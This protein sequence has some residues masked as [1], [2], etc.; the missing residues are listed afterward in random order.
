VTC[1]VFKEPCN[2]YT[3]VC[4]VDGVLCDFIPAIREVARGM[5]LDLP[6]PTVLAPDLRKLCGSPMEWQTLVERLLSGPHP[7]LSAGGDALRKALQANGNYL[8]ATAPIN[9]PELNGR[10]YDFRLRW[11][12]D[13]GFPAER[14][15]YM[16]PHAKAALNGGILIEDSEPTVKL[17]NETQRKRGNGPSGLLIARPWNTGKLTVSG[18][19]R[20][21]EMFSVF[22][23]GRQ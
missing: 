2:E 9:I 13:L 11:L 5:G 12:E 18:A 3:V 22:S 14:V 4:D 10:W 8:I 17:W 6:E 23:A 16:T 20:A 7:E 21:V 1:Q 15:Q 19:A